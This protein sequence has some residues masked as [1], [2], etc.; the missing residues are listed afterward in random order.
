MLGV[1]DLVELLIKSFDSGFNSL[2]LVLQFPGWETS[3]VTVCS[4]ATLNTAVCFLCSWYTQE[5]AG[6]SV[7]LAN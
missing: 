3:T 5:G 2:M 4:L 1:G 7:L 6:L